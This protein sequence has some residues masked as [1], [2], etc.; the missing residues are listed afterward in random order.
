MELRIIGQVEFVVSEPVWYDAYVDLLYVPKVPMFK[1][2]MYF[3]GA[4]NRL[5]T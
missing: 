3:Y 1:G 4:K 5:E 2:Q